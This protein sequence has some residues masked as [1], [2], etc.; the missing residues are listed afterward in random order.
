MNAATHLDSARQRRALRHWLR[1]S[2]SLSAHLQ[3]LGSRFEVQ[4]LVQQVMP[5]LPGEAASLGI[6]A[7]VRCL[8][9]EV[10]LRVDGQPLVW[11]RSVVPARALSGPWRHLGGLGSRP[12]AHLLFDSP[13]VRREALQALALS[14]PGPWRA[15]L[16]HGWHQAV[17]NGWP[18]RQAWGRH[19]VFHKA[20][21]P[22][23]VTEVFAPVMA[24][25]RCPPQRT[26]MRS[27]S[28]GRPSTSADS[29]S[30][31]TTAATPAGV[32]L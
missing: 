6:A 26:V 30:P 7:R 25:L 22:L 2:G 29:T 20:G 18:A 15:R 10:V 11:A 8:V 17:G 1:R 12:L 3:T 21:A 24:G 32:P 27:C 14:T 23:R 9:R 31:A 19:S 4:T 13:A 16:E 28:G 5:L